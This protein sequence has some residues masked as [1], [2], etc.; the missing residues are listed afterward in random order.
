VSTDALPRQ[1]ALDFG[2]ERPAS[3]HLHRRR[4]VV[5]FALL[6]DAR[7]AASIAGLRQKLRADHGLTGRMRASE[8]LHLSLN[9]IGAFDALPTGIVSAAVRAGGAVRAA[10]FEVAFDRVMSFRSGPLRPLVLRCRDGLAALTAL[11][12]A[13]GMEM[14]R[15]G[16]RS[17]TGPVFTPHITLL[18]D[19]SVVAHSPLDDPVC[20]SVRE[21]VLVHSLH[22]GGRHIHLARWPLR[23]ASTSG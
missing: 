19:E 21:F 8:F 5:Y 16:L 4:N 12:R 20:W 6:P 2:Y 9:G 10:P 15:V 18:Y 14:R 17:G 11:H 3:V 1:F 13:L 23:E 22:G 7:A